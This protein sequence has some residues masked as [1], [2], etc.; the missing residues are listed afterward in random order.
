MEKISSAPYHCN[1]T[2]FFLSGVFTDNS[3]K[4]HQVNST[5]QP[6]EALDQTSGSSRSPAIISSFFP[7]NGTL[8]SLWWHS[9][10]WEPPRMS[11]LLQPLLRRMRCRHC[12]ARMADHP[13]FAQLGC[14][15]PNLL[16][17]HC[18]CWG[19]NQHLEGI[20]LDHFTQT[21]LGLRG[22]L[23]WSFHYIKQPKS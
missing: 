22:I 17:R 13:T 4:L 20:I 3:L 7:W 6:L 5:I 12:W 15:S 2:R 8:P 10:H 1:Q 9:G 16:K 19:K 23:I 18:F 14:L 21:I 11:R